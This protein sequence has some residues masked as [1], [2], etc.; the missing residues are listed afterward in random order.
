MQMRKFL[1][2]LCVVLV[3][4]GLVEAGLFS[5]LS[6]F[7]KSNRRALRDHLQNFFEIDPGKFYRSQQLTPEVLK[8]YIKRFGIKTLINLRGANEKVWYHAEQDVSEQMG[9]EFHSISMS[10][11]V[12]S[13]REDLQQLLK[14]YDEAPRPILV[15]C[16][17]GADR[18]GEA[19][20]LWLIEIQHK[21]KE[22]ALL[23]LAITYGHRK[24]VNSAKDFLIQIW[25]GREWLNKEYNPFDYPWLCREPV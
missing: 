11:V 2:L 9:V 10:A 16:M 17:G 1:Y 3:G 4:S 20:A 22:E 6:S 13:S 12:L 21:P 19:A 15:H 14:L 25:Q 8:T 23:Q 24:M 7:N 18:T 5:T